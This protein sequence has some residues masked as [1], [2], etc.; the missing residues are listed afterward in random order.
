MPSP[1]APGAARPARPPA[2]FSHLAAALQSLEPRLPEQPA[3]LVPNAVGHVPVH[4]YSPELVPELSLGE[5]VPDPCLFEH[6][7]LV[8][9]GQVE[10]P[11]RVETA[12]HL[13][14]LSQLVPGRLGRGIPGFLLVHRDVSPRAS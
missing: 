5:D 12:R 1:R 7:G 11:G 6:H 13:G 4:V 14:L 3:E 8:V 10:V 2:A 9:A